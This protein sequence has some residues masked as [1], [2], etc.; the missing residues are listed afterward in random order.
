M[1]VNLQGRGEGGE[2]GQPRVEKKC[3]TNQRGKDSRGG[4]LS[5]SEGKKK[6]GGGLKGGGGN[7]H[8]IF[9]PRKRGKRKANLGKQIWLN[10]KQGMKGD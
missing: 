6:R 5:D 2:S 9:G 4:G 3:R 7:G 8:H 1:V 10:Q